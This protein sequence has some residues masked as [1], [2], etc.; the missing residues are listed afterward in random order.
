M[1][2]PVPP[3]ERRDRE[4]RTVAAARAFAGGDG[5]FHDL[6]PAWDEAFLDACATGDLERFAAQPV[7]W[8]V[9]QAGH[10]SHEVRTWLAAYAALGV[11]GP[12][13]VT[14]RYYRPIREW[15]A[16]YGVTTAVPAGAGVRA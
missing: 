15:F 16:G 13:E 2:R 7:S 11:H 10:S 9:E 8:Y 3:G 14:D 4:E 5:A 1:R 6:N 12:H